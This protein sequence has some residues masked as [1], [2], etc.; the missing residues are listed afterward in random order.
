VL[1]LAHQLR[2]TQLG[3]ISVDGT[4]LAAH[5]SKHAAV[6]YQRAGEMIAQLE[7]EVKELLTCAQAADVA[8][9]KTPGLDLPAELQRRESR[10]A[11]LQRARQVIEERA[12]QL[13]AEQ[14]P[15]YEAKAAARQA[16]R[17][18]GEK[19]RGQEPVP[20]SAAPDPKAQYN[21]TDPES[22]IMK[23][24]NGS[25]FEQAYN[26]QAAVD[27][28]MIIVGARVSDA[29][30]DKQELPASVA[31]ISPVVVA[32]VKNVLADSGFYSEAAVAAVEQK[33]DGTPSGV[34]VYAA[35]EKTSHHKTV[36]DLLPQPE[37]P[38]PGPDASAKEQMAHR[39]KTAVGQA[40]YRLRKQT[41]EPVF[42]IIKEVMGFRRFR[43][44]GRAKV[45]LEWT[46]VCLS[47]NLRR[48][49]VLKNQAAAG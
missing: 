13:A 27:E 5:A 36:A 49:C 34:T 35:V 24:G 22:R 30:N 10:V 18:A 37:P 28:A 46:L 15:A 29:P 16:Q 4:K 20:P 1:H 6:S 19:P 25:H 21:F 43:L 32:E 33:P 17:A 45:S 3:S 39:L 14:Q 41:V 38:T 11:A 40:L 23:A 48:V 9:T 42:G 47:Y 7:L 26:A 8:E 31:A 2:L 12:R 44:R